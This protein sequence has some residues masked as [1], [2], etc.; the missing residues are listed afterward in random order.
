MQSK[1]NNPAVPDQHEGKS[2]DLEE[3]V[4]APNID[5]AKRIFSI[6]CQRL[7]QPASWHEVAGTLS[8]FF[9]PDKDNPDASIKENDYL[10]IDLPGP[11]NVAGEG[12]DWVRVTSIAEN[13]DPDA[14]ES[15]A[16]TL[17]TS[18]NPHNPAEGVAHF[19]NEGSTSSFVIKRNGNNVSASYHGR[20]ELPNNKEVNLTDKIRNS[21]V[22]IG[23]MAGLSELQWKS[24]LKGF[25]K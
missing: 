16:I 11:G 23:A 9:K 7:R 10:M 13:K 3:S 24:L 15:L 21:L 20:N 6:G 12:H 17:E 1:T 4:T 22:A 8:A 2:V 14:E 25:L 5:E 19:F 18:Q